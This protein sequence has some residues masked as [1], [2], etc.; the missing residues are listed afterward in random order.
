M[1]K[2]SNARWQ[3]QELVTSLGSCLELFIYQLT[4]SAPDC[5]I[6]STDRIKL[7]PARFQTDLLSIKTLKITSVLFFQTH[8]WLVLQK[9]ATKPVTAVW[10][11]VLIFA[12]VT[13]LDIFKKV[14]GQKQNRNFKA[15]HD[16][17]L[18]HTRWV[19][20]LNVTRLFTQ[21]CHNIK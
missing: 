10:D 4:V 11:S 19:L 18:I 5:L 16:V 9:E 3:R 21:H 1:S 7:L 2:T 15:T 8:L 14:S 6:T 20:G 17:F 12:N 13:P